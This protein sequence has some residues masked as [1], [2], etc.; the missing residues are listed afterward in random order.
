M[1]ATQIEG[2][3]PVYEA[4]R[5]GL[6]VRKIQVARTARLGGT[7]ARIVQEA[8]ARGIPVQFVD[9]RHLDA[10]S[11][12]GAHQGIVA[13]AHV[14]RPVELEDLLDRAA[15]STHPLLVLLDGIQDPHNLGAILRTA[16]AAG[17]QGAV[18]PKRRSAG[19][20]PA[21]AK[22]S[23]GAI[24]HLPVAVV[25]NL[26]RAVQTCRERGFRV[27]AADVRGE[28]YDRTDLRP[29]VA[30]VIGGEG[31]GVS[32][33]VRERCDGLVGIPMYG[34]VA[35]L[36]ASVAAGILL[37]EVTRQAR[38]CIPVLRPSEASVSP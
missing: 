9:P 2:R 18:I 34:R 8:R 30:L 33:L 25:P 15:S 5:S 28:P 20:T 13:F 31:S 12:T 37:Y 1:D 17:A 22:A 27:F 6:P 26:A 7:L 14:I 36:N 11:Q 19:L 35:S 23:A 16:E 4:L 10:I 21:V 24:A 38:G 3:N 29:P 32:R